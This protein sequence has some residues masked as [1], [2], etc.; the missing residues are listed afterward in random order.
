MGL[1]KDVFDL[2]I[3]GLNSPEQVF[4]HCKETSLKFPINYVK[5]FDDPRHNNYGFEGEYENCRHFTALI[6]CCSIVYFKTKYKDKIEIDPFEDK[7]YEP[8]IKFILDEAAKLNTIIMSESLSGDVDEDG[9]CYEESLPSY[10]CFKYMNEVA[11]EL[12]STGTSERIIPSENLAY[13]YFVNPGTLFYN[14]SN[15]LGDVAK[16]EELNELIGEAMRSIFPKIM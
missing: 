11:S 7:F 8:F 2:K 13:N 1:F 14:K 6:F 15:K 9:N 3:G 4:K 5:E 12:L 16:S 10:L